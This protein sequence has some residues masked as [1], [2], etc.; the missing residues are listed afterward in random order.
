MCFNGCGC[1]SVCV[2]FSTIQLVS[3]AT[4]CLSLQRLHYSF[5]YGSCQLRL[6]ISTKIA[7]IHVC[8]FVVYIHMYV[9]VIVYLYVMICYQF[10][11]NLLNQKKSPC[12]ALYMYVTIYSYVYV[13]MHVS[14]YVLRV[15]S[16]HIEREVLQIRR[17]ERSFV[18]KF[19]K[20]FMSLEI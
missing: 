10:V 18:V 9:Y 5:L 3:L 7:Y 16:M 2:W 13:C 15:Y 6:C 19:V 4:F 17:R 1:V 8:T 14:M 20:L 12:F 11:W